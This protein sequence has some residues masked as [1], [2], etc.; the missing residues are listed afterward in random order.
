MCAFLFC[1]GGRKDIDMDEIVLYQPSETLRLEV[2]L[3]D[4]TVWLTQDQL[5]LLFQRDKS[6][7]SRHL[8]NI[9]SEGELDESLVVAKI[10]TTSPHGAV[11]GKVAEA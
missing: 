10:A 5:V 9:F 3:E 11:E 7:I 2:K 6:V 8:R 4:E 1:G